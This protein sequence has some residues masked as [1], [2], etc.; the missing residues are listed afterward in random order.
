MLGNEA[1]GSD[2]NTLGCMLKCLDIHFILKDCRRHRLHI[3]PRQGE[4]SRDT[5]IV[6][7]GRRPCI[8]VS[9]RLCWVFGE[10]LE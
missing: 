4:K 7:C 8:S 2:P 10:N 1:L 5:V 3:V 9:G 6:F